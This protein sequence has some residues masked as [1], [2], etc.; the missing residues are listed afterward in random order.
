MMQAAQNSLLLPIAAGWAATSINAT[1]FRRN[2]LVSHGGFQY[3][4]FYDPEARVVLAKR[5]L[6]ET[7]WTVHHTPYKGN[8]LDAH[9]VISLAV[10]GDGYLHM[11]WDHH[12]HPLHYVCSLEPGSLELTEMLPMTGNKETHVTYPEF[13]ALPNGDLLFL[14]RDGASGRGDLMLKHYDVRRRTW[15][16]RGDAF[17][18]GGE[19]RNAYWQTTVDTRGA[20]HLSWVWRESPDVATNHDLAYACSTDG[21]FTW[22]KSSG[23]TYEL[24]ITIDNAEYACRVPQG[25]EL[26]NQTSMCADSQGRPYIATYWRPAGTEV[27][28]YHLVYHDG[29]GWQAQ[30]V[31]QRQTP[32]RLSGGGSKRVPISRP[33]IVADATGDTDKAYMLF[34]DEERGGRV[35]LAICDDLQT[36]HWRF[37][38]LT[39]EN[40]GMW[41]PN[42][43][44]AMW[45]ERKELHLLLQKVGQG[46]GEQPEAL[47]PQMVSVLVCS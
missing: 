34:R 20:I 33:Q 10:D 31:S 7:D 27:P 18:Y 12:V 6:D 39:S 1:I 38:D 28:Q 17:I 11:A 19:A 30:Q 44:P 46:D 41:E 21:G 3:A 22:R 29:Q 9:N 8:V 37:I 16:L 36:R 5:R 35:S 47:P 24:P 45:L 23:E 32:F 14:Y 2:A 26:M 4:A 42:Y 40:V 13:Y 25:S 43:D 15:S